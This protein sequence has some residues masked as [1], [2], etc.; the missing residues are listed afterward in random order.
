MAYEMKKISENGQVWYHTA[1]RISVFEWKRRIIIHSS[2]N[3]RPT[4]PLLRY[5]CANICMYK[6]R[7]Y[8]SDIRVLL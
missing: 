2:L 3:P 5:Y 8:F 6:F 4:H 1:R 7:E